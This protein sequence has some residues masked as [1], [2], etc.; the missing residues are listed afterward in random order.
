MT[1]G[2][3]IAKIL[4]EIY[5]PEPAITKIIAVLGEVAAVYVECEEC[6]DD[7]EKPCNECADKGKIV[8]PIDES[9]PLV[10]L[11]QLISYELSDK[12]VGPYIYRILDDA[13]KSIQEYWSDEASRE[14][15]DH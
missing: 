1:K 4:R 6:P 12:A 14:R 10:V 11:Y 9:P 5:V 13:R 15:E 3:E 8:E 2:E 7:K